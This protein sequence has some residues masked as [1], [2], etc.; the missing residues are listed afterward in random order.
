ML[1][2]AVHAYGVYVGETQMMMC[3]ARPRQATSSTSCCYETRGQP[4]RKRRRARRSRR[5]HEGAVDAPSLRRFQ[6]A[7]LGISIAH[8]RC[9][10]CG[11]V[12]GCCRASTPID[13]GLRVFAAVMGV[14]G[15]LGQHVLVGA[16]VRLGWAGVFLV[17]LV[18]QALVVILTGRVFPNVTI[19][20]FWTAFVVPIRYGR[21]L[22]SPFTFYR[23]AAI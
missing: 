1:R 14:V 5:E 22:V 16:A 4:C 9:L 13:R 11:Y 3:V 10:L 2:S 23:G 20:D 8:H 19:D 15:V 17:T 18:G 21:M 12:T 7:L 6:A